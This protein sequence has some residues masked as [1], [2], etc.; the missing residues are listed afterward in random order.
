[1]NMQHP[2]SL[3]LPHAR[4]QEHRPAPESFRRVLIRPP[5]KPPPAA[6]R[7]TIPTS[8]DHLLY[9]AAELSRVLVLPQPGAHPLIPRQ[10]TSTRSRDST[11]QDVPGQDLQV[12]K[13]LLALITSPHMAV[14]GTAPTPTHL[15]PAIQR[16]ATTT[17][18]PDIWTSGD[19]RNPAPRHPAARPSTA[20]MFASG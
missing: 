16:T 17:A 4:H 15:P 10:A 13:Q 3:Y 1:M 12:A 5:V 8:S 19:R 14:L 7:F 2:A 9:T 20:R 6:W 18:T 11:Q